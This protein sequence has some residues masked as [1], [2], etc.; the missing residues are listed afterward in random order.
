MKR[1]LVLFS[2]LLGIAA[3]WQSAGQARLQREV[4]HE[5]VMLPYYN[6]FDNLAFKVEG[7]NVTLLG[8]V[9]RP[10]LKTDA[11]RVIRKIEGVEKVDNQI[12]VL[13]LSPADDR[14]RFA[15]HRAVYGHSS[16]NRY[17]HMAVPPIHIVVKNGNVALE[18]V[19]GNQADSNI[20]G[21]QAK[22]VPGVFSVTNNLRVEK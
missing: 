8:Q 22:G 6:V 9:T 5:L 11:E 7:A 3:A 17:G 20:A 19:V 21:L 12:E 1:I 13:P 2:G 16:L 18:G 4:R 15:I 14:I 10:T